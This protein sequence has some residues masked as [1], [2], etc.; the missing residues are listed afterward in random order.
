MD[1]S[2]QKTFLV[3]LTDGLPTQDTQANATIP[4]LPDFA[5]DGFVATDKGGGG[6]TCPAAGPDGSA[7]G[8]C[9][10]NLA[11]YMYQHDLR[12]DIPGKQNVTTYVVGFGDDIAE[13]KDYLD[14]IAAA[15]GGKAYTQNDAAGPHCRAPGNFRGR[16]RERQRD[17]RVTHRR[18]QRLSYRTR[19]LN[20][21]VRFGVRAHQPRAL[22][23]NVKKY[24]SSTA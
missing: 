2:C 20:N 13:S 24:H 22:A 23:G 11:G 16:G 7:N 5:T 19:N 8:A 15:G 9:M 14:D 1:S 17:L 12:S 3:Y 4:T 21:A 10:V 18:G 6:A